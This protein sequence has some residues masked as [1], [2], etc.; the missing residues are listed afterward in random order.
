MGRLFAA[1]PQEIQGRSRVRVPGGLGWKSA[2]EGGRR[3]LVRRHDQ[4][5]IKKSIPN[6]TIAES[7]HLVSSRR[8]IRDVK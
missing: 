8:V 5:T 4:L 2:G 6:R 3:S 7:A 1:E